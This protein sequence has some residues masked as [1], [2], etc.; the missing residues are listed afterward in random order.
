MFTTWVQRRL[1]RV[2]DNGWIL[3]PAFKWDNRPSTGMNWYGGK[4]GTMQ[5][6]D[7]TH[8]LLGVL[9]LASAPRTLDESELTSQIANKHWPQ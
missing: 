3:A 1:N 6:L 9:L 2:T 8:V 4:A 5:W 7:P